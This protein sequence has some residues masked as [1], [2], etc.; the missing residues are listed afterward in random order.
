MISGLTPS[1]PIAPVEPL[2]VGRLKPSHHAGQRELPGPHR[3]VGVV[4]HQTEGE[5]A[6]AVSLAIVREARQILPPVIIIAEDRTPLVATHDHVIDRTR[7][8][9]PGRAGHQIR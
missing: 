6:E 9:E 4:A 1:S 2:R 8:L 7:G 3:Q 5:E